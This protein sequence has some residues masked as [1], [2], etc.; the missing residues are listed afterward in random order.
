M[1]NRM[2][3]RRLLAS[4]GLTTAAATLIGCQGTWSSAKGQS[5]GTGARRS[6]RLAHLTD[7]HVQPEKRAPEGLAAC[8]RHAQGLADPP[9]LILNG[10]DCILDCFTTDAE[11]A[12]T[13]WEVWQRVLAAE[14]HLPVIHCLGN[15]DI[16]GWDKASARTTGDEERFGKRWA[17]EE[18]GVER[19]YRSFDR[20]GWHFIVLDSTSSDGGNYYFAR[21]DDE[22]FAWLEEDLA[23]LAGARPVV[24]L[25]HI[26]I[27]SAASFFDGENEKPGD[28]VVPRAWMHIDARRIKD[29]FLKHPNVRLCLSGHL[30]LVD[31]VEY[32]GVTY[33]CDGAVCAGW[34]DG[35]YQE[36]WPGYGVVDLYEDGSF[37][38]EYVQFGWEFEQS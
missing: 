27:L 18:F 28:W 34:W 37:S 6:L 26:P 20:D 16:W 14:C 33:I 30:H 24:V 1:P 17:L 31:R 19:H 22:Q 15:H 25:S 5:G 29:L 12:R 36:C 32:C 21:L 2:T 4:A 13:Q 23:R 35:P 3:R 38:H 7:V 8:L 9:Q 10:G 11:R